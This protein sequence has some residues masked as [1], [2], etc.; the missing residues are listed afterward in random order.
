MLLVAQIFFNFKNNANEAGKENK[1][2]ID[3]HRFIC[4]SSDIAI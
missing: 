3:V 1:I 2:A 4:Y